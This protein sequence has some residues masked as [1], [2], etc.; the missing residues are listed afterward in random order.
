MFGLR[1][2]LSSLFNR[3]KVDE[4]LFESLEESLLLADVG[5]DAT[6]VLLAQ[7][8]SIAKKEK[9]SD[10]LQ[11]KNRLESLISELL[12]PLEFNINPLTQHIPTNIPEIWLIV[13]VNGAGK[14]TTIGKLC[15][16]L[17]NQQKKIMLA[18]GDTFRAA[19]REQL[20]EWG[21]KNTVDVIVQTSGD[22]STVAHDA[23][24]AAQARQMDVLLID[25][26]GRLATQSHL[27]EELRKV[28]RVIQ[29][30]I[31]SAPHQTILVL[32]GNT[33]Q[34]G[35]SQVKAFHESLTLSGLIITKIDGTAKGGVLCAIA[36]ALR[37][38]PNPPKILGLGV[39][40]QIQ[41]LQV[42]TAQD[43]AKELLQND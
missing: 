30:L 4:A 17:Q 32:D 16:T 38:T 1:K 5:I 7:L 34:N 3:S 28:K 18:A 2:T 13:G 15:H 25:T 35:L 12:S 10:A 31:P 33:G 22:A 40:E 19:A 26:A 42:F 14:T 9:I 39:G 8:R 43:F 24:G 37:L 36:Q 6:S 41:Q 21:R 11:L 20:V 29:K 27:M 23:I